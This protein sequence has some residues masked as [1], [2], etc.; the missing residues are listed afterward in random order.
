[1]TKPS[2]ELTR[3]LAAYRHAEQ[4]LEQA[5]AR[6]HDQIAVELEAG[7][8]QAELVR[9][10]GYTRETLRRIAREHGLPAAS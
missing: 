1:M 3:A 4:Q 5:R 6:L 7:V 2:R 9:A 8:R 10:T